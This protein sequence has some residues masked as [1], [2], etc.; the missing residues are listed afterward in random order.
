MVSGPRYHEGGL[1]TV[2]PLSKS[3]SPNTSVMSVF[4]ETCIMQN[5]SFT[6]FSA[7][8]REMVVL[9]M[10]V[11]PSSNTAESG[12]QHSIK[13]KNW[14]KLMPV[15]SVIIRHYSMGPSANIVK[16]AATVTAAA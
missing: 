9:P 10:P 1:Y 16:D 3:G 2:R 11:S 13:S 8:Y 12:P 5:G 15:L 7:K 4:S 14:A 6:I